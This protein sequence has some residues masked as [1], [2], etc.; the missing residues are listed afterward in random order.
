MIEKKERVRLVDVLGE[1]HWNR[2]HL[3]GSEWIDFRGL[4][5]EARRRFSSDESLVLYCAGFT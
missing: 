3:P 1:E 2:G 5:R 4:A